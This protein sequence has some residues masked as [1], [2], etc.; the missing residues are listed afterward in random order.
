MSFHAVIAF[1]DDGAATLEAVLS[2][3]KIGGIVSS[4][5]EDMLLICSSDADAAYIRCGLELRPAAN[6]AFLVPV[7]DQGAV[8][9]WLMQNHM[10]SRCEWAALEHLEFFCE[11]A[12]DRTIEV[13]SDIVGHD[14]RS[15][16]LNLWPD[17]F[18]P[19]VLAA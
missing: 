16:P 12:V 18:R 10:A 5:M 14:P 15:L 2:Q 13:F 8:A 19:N 1:P 6:K 3:T 17:V 11:A 7:E 4:P 9:A